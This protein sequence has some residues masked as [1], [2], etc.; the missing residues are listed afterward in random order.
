[1]PSANEIKQQLEKNWI[2][3]LN[4]N[5]VGVIATD[6]LWCYTSFDICWT[7]WLPQVKV[8]PMV[9]PLI[10]LGF[11]VDFE[12]ANGLDHYPPITGLYFATRLGVAEHLLKRRH[13]TTALI[14]REIRP[15]YVMPL[16]VWQVR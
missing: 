16:G 13:K 10:N 4:D 1:M 12:N 3:F 7:I 8:G 11:G 14:L 6:A 9:P 5:S 15:E 2:K